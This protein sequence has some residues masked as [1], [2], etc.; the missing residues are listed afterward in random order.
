MYKEK[1]KKE[2]YMGDKY[3][4]RLIKKV[5]DALSEEDFSEEELEELR[6]LFRD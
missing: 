4:D 1:I 6:E 3:H 2:K 5:E